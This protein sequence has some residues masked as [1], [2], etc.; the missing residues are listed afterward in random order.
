MFRMIVI[1]AALAVVAVA[2]HLTARLRESRAQATYPPQG[3]M[4]D[5][6]GRQ[7][8]AVVM[9][10][11]PDVV[12][13]HGASGSTR[14]MTFSF[15]Q[16]LAKRYRV[17]ALDRPG[18]GY[19]P[20]RGGWWQRRSDTLAEQ[21]ALLA[22]AAAQLGADRPIVV[23]QSYG[24]A[25][26]LAWALDHPAAALVQVGGVSHPWQAPPS[27][28]NRL[29]ATRLGAATLVPLATALVPQT[30]VDHAIKGIF[31][32]DPVPTG[33]NRQVGAG[34]TLRRATLR[35][36]ARQLVDLKP[37]ITAQSPRYGELTLPIEIVHGALDTTV[38]LDIHAARLVADVP[39]ATLERLP[40]T[41]H[42][43]H[44]TAQNAVIAAV[45][46]AAARAG[47]R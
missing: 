16:R 17:I 28:R 33:Y 31:A 4:L 32:P 39:S 25:V 14:D 23:G 29:F 5:V 38:G 46:R 2:V 21:A 27:L 8:H 47:L 15:A 22:Q 43:P 41:G 1:L 44:H 36:N 3:R 12:L 18:F 40:Q 9:G 6:S 45:D 26:S 30:M 42:M 34:L 13:I 20:A 37:A 7:V 11:G 24:G 10:S 19:T 35:T